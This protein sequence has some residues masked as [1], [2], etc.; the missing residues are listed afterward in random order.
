MCIYDDVKICVNFR[1]DNLDVICGKEEIK[2]HKDLDKVFFK[3]IKYEI[4]EKDT[5]Q[6]DGYTLYRIKAT[7]DFGDIKKGT[8]GGYICDYT[9]LSPFITDS[10]W[11]YDNA[12]V[13]GYSQITDNVKIYDNSIVKN[14]YVNDNVII[15]NNSKIIDCSLSDNVQTFNKSYIKL[16]TLN[17]NI[18]CYNNT[19]I[20]NSNLTS[21]F[22]FN[23]NIQSSKINEEYFNINSYKN[24]K[25]TF[26]YIKANNFEKTEFIKVNKKAR[27]DLYK[28]KVKKY[29]KK[30]IEIVYDCI[31]NTKKYKC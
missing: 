31:K 15:K 21:N 9:N 1:I 7:R 20:I 17:G 18:Q 27:K 26:F 29:Q 23:N 2:S 25:N 6:L 24:K 14:S 22:V 12:K 3:N 11:V 19:K 16:S 8:I 4:L 30:Y 10:C 28:L 5:L 13:Y